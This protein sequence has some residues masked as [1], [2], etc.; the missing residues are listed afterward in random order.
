MKISY[1][2]DLHLDFWCPFVSNQIKWRKRTEEFILKLID[3]D[4]SERDVLIIAGDMSHFNRQ[5]MWAV[6]LFSMYYH[7]VFTTY[8]NHELYLISRNQSDKYLDNSRNR[9]NEFHAMLLSMPN[10]HPLFT[11]KVFTYKGVTFGG[12]PMWYPIEMTEQQM[13]FSN[14]S[15]D[16]KLIKGFNIK[17]EH[18]INQEQYE[19]LLTKEIDVMISHFPVINTDSH[20]KYNSAAC[21]LTPVKDIRAKHWVSGH[22]HEQ[23]TYEKPYCTFYMNAIGYPPEKLELSIR[24]FNI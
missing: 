3:T 11:D 5:S 16:S 17:E 7:Q 19:S 6:E 8:G 24:S 22:V 14:I 2:S 20:F 18:Y 1:I 10:V 23:K 12:N 15:N 21:Y 13:F 9:L 4:E